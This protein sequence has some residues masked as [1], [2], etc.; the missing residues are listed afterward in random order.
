MIALV[1]ERHQFLSCIYIS[2][3]YEQKCTFYDLKKDLWNNSLEN[4]KYTSLVDNT[5]G[6]DVFS[7]IRNIKVSNHDKLLFI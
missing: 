3:E 1:K 2:V 5:K 7:S 4:R 6:H